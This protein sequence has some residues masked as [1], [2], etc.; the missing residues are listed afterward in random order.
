[1][2]TGEEVSTVYM[3]PTDHVLTV[4]MPKIWRM[5]QG[6][7]SVDHTRS[8][9]L[10]AKVGYNGESS[11]SAVNY[12]LWLGT[13][14]KHSVSRQA[15]SDI[16]EMARVDSI[17]FEISTNT[18]FNWVDHMIRAA[19]YPMRGTARKMLGEAVDLAM[20]S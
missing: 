2:G 17:R 14:T 6:A 13:L 15:R 7:V 10:G 5:L 1:M 9:T 3:T 19:G 8:C 11:A 4:H 18:D 20:H 12:S 16:S